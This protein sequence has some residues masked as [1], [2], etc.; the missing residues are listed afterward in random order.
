MMR[1]RELLTLLGS[2]VAVWPWPLVARAQQPGMPRVGMLIGPSES[3]PLYRSDATAFKEE[4]SKRG[5]TEGRDLRID[6]R[7]GEGDARRTLAQA[8]ELIN[9]S[10]NVVFA[11]SALST[12]ALQ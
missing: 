6:V 12:R 7:F 5:W 10:P 1:R 8:A 11:L 2:A 9:L 4:L 3:D